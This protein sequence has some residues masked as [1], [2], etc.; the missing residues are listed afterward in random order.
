MGLHS[1][2]MMDSSRIYSLGWQAR[3]ELSAG[4]RL[5]YLDFV[6]NHA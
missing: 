2:D 3:V 6:I 4:L 1:I 5:A